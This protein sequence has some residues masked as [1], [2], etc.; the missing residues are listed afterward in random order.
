[1]AAIINASFYPQ[2]GIRVIFSSQVPLIGNSPVPVPVPVPMPFPIPHPIQIPFPIPIPGPV[3]VITESISHGQAVNT[4]PSAT[5]A[6]PASPANTSTSPN[7][8]GNF[9]IVYIHENERV[10]VNNYF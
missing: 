4:Q 1:M 5:A 6:P 3:H 7:T 10:V 8:A 2:I 9:G